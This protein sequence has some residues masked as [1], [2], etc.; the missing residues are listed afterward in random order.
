MLTV[1]STLREGSIDYV[2]RHVI[3]PWLSESGGGTMS[4]W[5]VGR[6]GARDRLSGWI[7]IEYYNRFLFTNK[8]L[9][10]KSGLSWIHTSPLRDV[11]W[12]I[13]HLPRKVTR[14]LI[15]DI[16]VDSVCDE[17]CVIKEKP[18]SLMCVVTC[19]LNHCA[20][21]LCCVERR[22]QGFLQAKIALPFSCW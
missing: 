16:C 4:C 7:T 11:A 18:F 5:T 2:W 14:G 1:G 3:A 6:Q 15:L 20:F 21:K 13:R 8:S 10:S 12:S 17:S 9:Y 19:S 22:V